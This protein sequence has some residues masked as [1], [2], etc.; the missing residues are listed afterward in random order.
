[1]RGVE[2][3]GPFHRAPEMSVFSLKFIED[4]TSVSGYSGAS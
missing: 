3:K 2:V 1:M 4:A